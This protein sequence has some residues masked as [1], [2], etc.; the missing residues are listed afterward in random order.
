VM[1]ANKTHEC[2]LLE[3]GGNRSAAP[4]VRVLA[5]H[6]PDCSDAAR[7]DVMWVQEGHAY[8]DTAGTRRG[9]H[10]RWMGFR[11]NGASSA[12]HGDESRYCKARIIVEEFR[13]SDVINIVLH[14]GV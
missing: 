2:E 10:R 5:D 8:R 4:R 14:G 7:D 11:C 6:S 12:E 3:R 1:K 9:S 13:L